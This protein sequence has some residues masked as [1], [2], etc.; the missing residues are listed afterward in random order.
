MSKEH[1][2]ILLLRGEVCFSSSIITFF[3]ACT[4]TAVLY[5]WLSGVTGQRACLHL[6]AFDIQRVCTSVDTPSN[7]RQSGAIS[8]LQQRSPNENVCAALWLGQL[9]PRS[10]YSLLRISVLNL[11]MLH[12]LRSS[13]C[14]SVFLTKHFCISADQLHVWSLIVQLFSKKWAQCDMKLQDGKKNFQ[15]Y[16]PVPQLD[17]KKL[18]LHCSHLISEK[19]AQVCDLLIR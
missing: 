6:R 2:Q 16:V 4:S 17:L 14:K 1:F 9:I 15:T 7:I 8:L 19:A 12:A 5:A 10:N 18:L 13:I 3:V 11:L